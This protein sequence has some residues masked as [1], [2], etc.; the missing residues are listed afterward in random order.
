V[1]VDWPGIEDRVL[2][3]PLG[4]ARFQRI[5][6]AHGRVFVSHLPVEGALGEEDTLGGEPAA[7]ATLRVYEFAARKTRT[8]KDIRRGWGGRACWS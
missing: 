5:E 1:R 2:S 7:R 4:D 6:G 8:F 3:L